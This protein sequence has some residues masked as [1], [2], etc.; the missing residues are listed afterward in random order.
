MYGRSA[1]TPVRQSSAELLSAKLVS[2][3]N[4]FGVDS[5]HGLH[6]I[7]GQVAASI[8]SSRRRASGWPPGADAGGRPHAGRLVDPARPAPV[9]PVLRHGWRLH[10]AL[11]TA[12]AAGWS[13]QPSCARPATSMR[14][15]GLARSSAAARWSGYPLIP[16][17]TY[18]RASIYDGLPAALVEQPPL[19]LVVAH[20]LGARSRRS[21]ARFAPFTVGSVSSARTTRAAATSW[22]PSSCT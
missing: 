7:A 12:G 21:G 13:S 16:P 8:Q 9:R 22:P 18:S 10:A 3:Q 4:D 19:L 17:S 11:G 6:V 20:G 2:L 15:G 5:Y 14:A 1:T